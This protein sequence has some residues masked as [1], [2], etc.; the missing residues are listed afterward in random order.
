MCLFRESHQYREVTRSDP[1]E[2]LYFFFQASYTIAQITFTTVRI[3][4]HLISF[5]QILYDLFHIHLSHCL[6]LSNVFGMQ[7]SIYWYKTNGHIWGRCTRCTAIRPGFKTISMH[8]TACIYVQALLD[9][10]WKLD[11]LNNWLTLG[12]YTSFPLCRDSKLVTLYLKN[13]LL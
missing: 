11:W 9:A 7:A 3:I 2:V 13:R 6:L 10:Y 5:L 4:L 12:I 8:L 1:I